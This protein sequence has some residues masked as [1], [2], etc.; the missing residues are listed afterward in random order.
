MR[1]PIVKKYFSKLFRKKFLWAVAIA[2]VMMGAVAFST[3][4]ERYFEIAKN[5]EI[6]ASVF[7]E[8]NNLYVDDINP[9]Q[10]VQ[11]GID[12][13][14]AS[15][16]PYTNYIPE[17]EVED[18]RTTNT[19]Q[20]G[21]IG[22]TTRQLGNRTVVTEVMP[23]Y[24]ADKGGLKTGDEILQIN[25]VDLA[26][27]SNE[28]AGELMK[29]Q[30]GKPLSL[31]VKRVGESDPLTLNFVREHITISNV[32]Y[33]GMVDKDIGY[34]QLTEFTED[35]GKDVRSALKDVLD[36]GAKGII[37]DLR[38]NPGGL[39]MEAV[40]VC[41]A[42][43]DKG[44]KVVSTKGKVADHNVT[45][46]TLNEP[47]DT[48]IPLVILVNR[49]SASASEIV[50]GTVQDYDR[51]VIMGERSYGKGLVQVS[52][53]L[54]YNAQLKVTTAKYYT[55]SG[56]CIQVL[57]YS[58]RRPDGSVASVPDSLK[59]EFRTAHNRIVYDGG[60][61]DPDEKV[62]I[63]E[64]NPL[65]VS[66]LE[67]GVIFDYATEYA[68][69]K[70]SIPEPGSFEMSD[71]DYAQFVN[72]AHAHHYSYKSD[73]ETTLEELNADAQNQLYYGDLKPSIQQVRDRIEDSR[74]N[75]LTLFRKQIQR[76][77]TREIVSRF[78]NQSGEVQ[79]DLKNDS[80][81]KDAENLLHN[82]AKYNSILAGPQ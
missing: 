2:L 40:D 21:G 58:H 78:Y 17:D 71:A 35:A 59:K 20:Y 68:Y 18:F 39:L 55:P 44:K 80:E 11:S 61:I 4:G 23:G 60:G 22:I 19:G 46:E 49:G 76:E 50:S 25:G 24:S 64:L 30:V 79:W 28:E 31:T 3:P 38:D 56:R 42:F 5:L 69:E 57:D 82:S 74:K 36:Q 62:N 43:L 33:S 41:N 9:N 73:L 53:P 13:M 77:L 12:T 1:V 26:T 54:S 34:I 63:E 75:E 45:Y 47:V 72:W 37:L 16:D 27:L 32:P 15:L 8:V 52:R 6:F 7:K 81:I 10:L 65:T 48:K 66:L 70:K 29:G 51:G 14:L 67:S